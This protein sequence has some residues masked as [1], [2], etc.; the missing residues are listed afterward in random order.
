M[1]E[2]TIVDDSA[3]ITRQPDRRQ[4]T[5][6]I[7]SSQK[8]DTGAFNQLVLQWEGR[9]YNLSLRMLSNPDEAAEATQEVFLSAFRNIGRFRLE[10]RFSTW[11]YRIA[12]NRCLTRLKQRP[13]RN[14]LTIDEGGL[15][16]LQVAESQE[17]GV[18]RREQRETIRRALAGLRDK[19]RVVV[20]LKIFQERKFEEIAEILEI[21]SSTVKSRFYA[22]LES[23]KGSL[24][25]FAPGS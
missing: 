20:E 23:L 14:E 3:L 22:A 12:S 8:G 1:L 9:I 7:R 13:R 5:E 17:A 15:A 25:S 16:Q 6:W 21:P 2:N 10:A 4:E 24:T 19:Q 18:F 11:L